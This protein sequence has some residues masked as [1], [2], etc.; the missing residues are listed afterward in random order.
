[1]KNLHDAL[2]EFVKIVN[3]KKYYEV[4]DNGSDKGLEV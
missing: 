3:D 1:M 2:V 4:K